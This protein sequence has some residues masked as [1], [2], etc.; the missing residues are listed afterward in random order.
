MLP[1]LVRPTSIHPKSNGPDLSESGTECVNVCRKKKSI[2]L[3]GTA[4]QVPCSTEPDKG[5]LDN[6]RT[7]LMVTFCVCP[8]VFVATNGQQLFLK[9]LPMLVTWQ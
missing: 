7:G 8:F 4:L 5:K 2:I 1:I 6:A 3:L 9:P